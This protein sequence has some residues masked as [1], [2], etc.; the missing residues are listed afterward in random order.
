MPLVT[1]ISDNRTKTF[2]VKAGERLLDALRE[3]NIQIYAPCG[4]NGVC[5]KCRVRIKGEGSVTSCLYTVDKPID[6]IL[7]DEKET[8]VLEKQHEYTLNLPLLPGP[9]AELVS[10]PLGVAIDIGTTTI[11]CYLVDLITGS[12]IE[13]KSGVNPQVKYGADVISRIQ[14]AG[15]GSKELQRLQELLVLFIN[16]KVSQFT[17]DFD[18]DVSFV[19]KF[20]VAANNTMLHLLKGVDPTPLALVPF[21][22]QF[23][24]Q[25][26]I[27]A[28]KLNI[29]A[30]PKAKVTLLP[31]VSA[32]VGADIVAGIA[33]IAPPDA[34][35][36]Y[37][38]LDI[39]TNGEL[40]L[41][42]PDKILCCATAAGPALEGANITCGTAAVAGAISKISNGG[43]TVI[44]NEKPMGICGSGLIDLIALLCKEQIIANDGT[45]TDD[46]IVAQESE[47]SS[48]TPVYLTQQDVRE[49]QLAKSAIKSGIAILTQVAGLNYNQIDALFLAGGFGNYINIRNAITIGL[50]PQELEDK[51][52][53]VGNTSATGAI[54]ALKSLEFDKV[55]QNVVS[56]AE[57]IELNTNEN[58]QYEFVMNMNFY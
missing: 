56:K 48:G 12:V 31:S 49:V 1:I 44:G 24:G 20:V 47:T 7:P 13:S 3:T 14:Y 57:L 45:L 28:N 46:Y 38:F 40:A 35:K 6:V 5:G 53:P 19:V 10:Y 18:V 11:V 43:Y 34:V 23:T 50:L 52:V 37:L 9:E 30:N 21:T 41:V 22:P 16:E 54:F 36:N 32:Y 25:Q 17:N 15:K 39:G 27:P 33:S 8:K 4:G 58:F 29:K 55:M 42:T 26:E 2:R 51:V